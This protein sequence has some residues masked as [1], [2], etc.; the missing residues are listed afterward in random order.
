MRH[1]SPDVI[2]EQTIL[3]QKKINGLEHLKMI[4]VAMKEDLLTDDLTNFGNLLST[5]WQHKKSLSSKI[6]NNAIEELVVK[7]NNAG[8]EGL[9]ITGAGGGGVFIIYCNWKK[10]Q[11]IANI[12]AES[13]CQIIDFTIT[14][15]GL[16]TWKAKDKVV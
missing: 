7:A 11:H 3:T 2:K 6:S 5:D 14:K 12:M 1:N 13:G 8:A 9:K 10:K 4:A 16:E 15:T